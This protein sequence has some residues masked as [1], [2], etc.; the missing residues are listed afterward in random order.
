LA[1]I[2][3]ARRTLENWKYRFGC[4]LFSYRP[5]ERNTIGFGIGI[6]SASKHENNNNVWTRSI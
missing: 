5:T 4:K 3:Q 1:K 6:P 2:A